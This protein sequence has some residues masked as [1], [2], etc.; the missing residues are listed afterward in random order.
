MSGKL[1]PLREIVIHGRGGQ[2]AV[3]AAELIAKAAFYDGKES[4]A[5]PSFGV[6]RRGAPVQAFCRIS[7]SRITLKSQVYEPDYV[8]ILD[9]TLLPLVD[10]K[11]LSE[12]KGTLIVNTANPINS[13]KFPGINILSVDASS[14]ALEIFKADI[15]NTAMVAA[16]SAFTGEISIQSVIKALP[17]IFERKDIIEKNQLALK[18]IY[19]KCNECK[20][21]K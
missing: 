14:V 8:I 7:E 2:G 6:E 9:S 5:F 3:T 10:I 4:Q 18:K 12:R 20:P 15:V 11:N 16:F 1:N 19:S 17:E 21:G 13:S